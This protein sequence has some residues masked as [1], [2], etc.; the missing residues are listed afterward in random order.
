MKN[1]SRPPKRSR[2]LLST[3]LSASLYCAATS[4][5]GR[6]PTCL[7]RDTCKPTPIAQ[8]NSAFLTPPSLTIISLIRLCTFSKM[9]GTAPMIVGLMIA[10]FSTILST[11][12]SMTVGKPIASGRASM[13]LPN[14][15]DSG[16]QR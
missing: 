4:A 7:A 6:S 3:S 12:P 13:T 16:S 14:A 5:D 15:W 10:R 1:R 8:S 11:R 9:R 2:I